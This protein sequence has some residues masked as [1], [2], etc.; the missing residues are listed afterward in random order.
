MEFATLKDLPKAKRYLTQ[1]GFE[2]K[3]DNTTLK[4]GRPAFYV[5]S[6]TNT[7]HLADYD[8]L[9]FAS[10]DAWRDGE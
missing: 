3:K 1:Q 10:N 2:V 7:W 4:G 6:S 5:R 9:A 8:L